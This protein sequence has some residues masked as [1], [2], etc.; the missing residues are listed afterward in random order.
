MECGELCKP[1]EERGELAPDL[2]SMSVAKRGGEE[3]AG[4]P[5][6]ATGGVRGWLRQFVPLR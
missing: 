4:A 2:N 1:T 3:A 6:G 5:N